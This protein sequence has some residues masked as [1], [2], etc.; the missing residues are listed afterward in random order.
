MSDTMPGDPGVAG[1]GLVAKQVE[2]CLDWLRQA[3]ELVVG[4]G[5]LA[6]G[7]TALY[8]HTDFGPAGQDKETNQDYALAWVGGTSAAE[9]EPLMVLAL[10]DGLTSSYRSEW[11]SEL[12]CAVAIQTLVQELTAP[13]TAEGVGPSAREQARRAFA[14]AGHSLQEVAQAM[15]AKPEESCPPGTFLS[16]WKY[17]LRKGGL[18]QT[19][20]TLAWQ[21]GGLLRVAMLGDGGVL[22][23]DNDAAPVPVDEVLAQ[24]DLSTNTV[25]AL[26][27]GT[28]EPSALDFWLER[29][30]TGR[31]VCALSSDGVGRGSQLTKLYPLD[32]VTELQC[33]GHTN[34]AKAWIDQVVQ[35]SHS[36]FDDNLTLAILRRE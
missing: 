21:R 32:R 3:G 6:S 28:P 12:A 15:A 18:L 34:P 11:A 10:A 22:W 2:T 9:A 20:L 27:P 23:R 24:A 31:K 25:N 35:E 36:A 26:G 14:A 19:T 30:W 17:I 4:T 29:P 33:Q 5:C 7:S 8:L 13:L 1:V 16:T